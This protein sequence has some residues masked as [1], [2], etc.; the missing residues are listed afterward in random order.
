[1]AGCLRGLVDFEGDSMEVIASLRPAPIHVP[2]QACFLSK[3][4]AEPKEGTDRSSRYLEQ[5]L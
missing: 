2:S 4:V 3:V 1:M 5:T